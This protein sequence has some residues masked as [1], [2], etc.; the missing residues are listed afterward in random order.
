MEKAEPAPPPRHVEVAVCTFRRPA[1]AETLRSVAAQRLP[2]G[3]ALGVIVADND[4]TPSARDLVEAEARAGR[5]SMRYVHAPARNIAVARN[6]CLDAATAPWLAF[7]DDD[8]TAEPDWLR[9]LLQTADTTGADLVFGP[10]L[11]VYPPGAPAW[12]RAADLHSTRPTIRGGRFRGG[13]AGN[14][15][16][17]RA[18]LGTARF[19]AAFGRSGGEDTAFFNHLLREGARPAFSAEAIAHE[20]VPAERAALGWLL[21]RWFRYGQ[22]LGR[23]REAEGTSRAAAAMVAAAKAGCCLGGAALQLGSAAGWR[24]WLVRGALHAGAVAHLL[25]AGSAPAYGTEGKR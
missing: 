12:L 4:D 25:G 21:R 14:C 19:D 24:R 15:L 5:L 18:A 10:V 13:Y 17:R 8:E 11:A 3:V 23:M 7:L 9:H 16:L 6:A 1:L 2:P 20:P 22:T